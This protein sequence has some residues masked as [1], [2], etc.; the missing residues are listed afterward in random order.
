MLGD[1]LDRFDDRLLR[2]QRQLHDAVGDAVGQPAT[3]DEQHCG[4]RRVRVDV[5]EDL[6]L[7]RRVHRAERVVEHEH[8]WRETNACA[9]RSADAAHPTA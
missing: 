8:A 2:G 7:E 5:G 4:L 9:T 1:L 3:G 6:L